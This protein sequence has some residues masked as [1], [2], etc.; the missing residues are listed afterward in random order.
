M[1]LGI[2]LA[3]AAVTLL[4]TVD[5]IGLAPI[6][7]ALT[8]GLDRADRRAVAIRAALIAFLVLV[9][10]GLGGER[11]LALLGIGLPSFRVSGGILLFW[12]AFEMVFERRSDRKQGSAQ[13]AVA[14]DHIRDVAAFPLAIPLMSGP[15][16]ITAIML[17]A[18]QAGPDPV[19]LAALALVVAGVML[20]CLSVFL[21]AGRVAS[22]LGLTGQTVL[23]RLLGIVLAAL[24][25]QFVADGGRALLAG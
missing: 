8:Q 4:V 13:A 11:L 24:A 3:S 16:S 17:L 14:T 19:A 10:F 1:N 7:L 25:V 5:P 12:I 2:D 6:F 15:G 23:S 21:A 9:A 20:A 22:L 18:G